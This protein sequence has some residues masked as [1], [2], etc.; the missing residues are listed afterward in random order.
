MTRIDCIPVS[1]EN[2]LWIHVT[3]AVVGGGVVR[4]HYWNSLKRPGYNR[5]YG[6]RGLYR[7]PPTAH[8]IITP[9]LVLFWSNP[10]PTLI[11]RTQRTQ[12]NPIRF[13][14]HNINLELKRTGRH[15]HRLPPTNF[16]KI[17]STAVMAGSA[18]AE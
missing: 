3:F 6:S 7:R 10:H 14:T 11:K 1:Q 18:S 4:T 5:N 16:Q 12:P 8:Q 17:L 13:R 2:N 9:P 15:P